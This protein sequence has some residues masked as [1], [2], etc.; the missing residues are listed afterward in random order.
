MG[1]S[2]RYELPFTLGYENTGW[3][4]ALGAGVD[5]LG[6]MAVHILRAVSA[7][8]IVAV[9]LDERKLGRAREPRPTF[10]LPE[11][12]LEVRPERLRERSGDRAERRDREHDER[13]GEDA[14][15]GASG[16]VE[17]RRLVRQAESHFPNGR[18]RPS[19]I[20]PEPSNHLV[21]SGV[22]G[23]RR[24][25]LRRWADG[26]EGSPVAELRAAGR[27]LSVL[28]EENERLANRLLA[29]ERQSGEPPPRVPARP[30]TRPR[31][32]R[33]RPPWQLAVAAIAIVALVAG[34]TA[35]A[36]RG[37]LDAGGAPSRGVVGA[38]GLGGLAFWA[39]VSDDGQA[40]WRL[41]GK[42]VSA[43]REGERLLL[44]PGKLPDGPHVVE[45]EVG[46]GLFD[47]AKKRFSFR[48]DTS[49]PVL[50]LDRPAAARR[51]Q[52]VQ[53]SGETEPGATIR[54]GGERVEVGED[55]RF[56]VRLAK[57]PTSGGV[58]L[59]V[60]DVA[61]NAS[62]WRVPVTVVPRRPAQP[63][64]AVHVTAYGWADDTLREGVLRL[65]RENRINAVE[66]DLKDE[67]GLVGWDAP[68]P[69]G[70]RIG[71]IEDVFDLAAAVR[72]LHEL[73]VRVIGRLVCFRD[74][75]HATAAWKA[76]RRDEVV[77]TPD[78]GPY[79][80]YG[81]FTNFANESVRRYNI[82]VA[83][84]A[85][86]LGVDEILYDYVRRPDGPLSSMRL[87]G[88]RGTAERSIA[89]FLE[90]SRAALTGTDALLGASVFGIAA[91]R[92][93][94]IAQDIPAIARVVD[95][96]SPMVYPS[97]WGPGEYGVSD[98]NGNPYAITRRSLTDFV[99][100]TRGTGARVVPWLQ[101]FSLGRTYGTAE[102]VA[103]I[104][105]ARD[106][107]ADEFLLWDASVTYT[108]A[109]LAPSAVRPALDVTAEPRGKLPGPKRLT[110]RTP[111]NP[112]AAPR[113]SL[114]PNELGVVPVVMHHEIRPDRVGAYDQTPAEFRAELEYLWEQGYIPVAAAEYARGDMD[115]PAGKSP[116]VLT[117]DDSTTYQLTLDGKGR[118]QP[119]TAVG[120][121][122]DFARTH[123][124]FRATGTF[125]VLREPFGGTAQSPAL[126]RWLVDRGFELGNHGHDHIALRTLGD[127]AVRQ[128]LVRGARVITDAVPGYEIRSMAL[129]LGSEPTRPMLA[130]RGRSDGTAY[131]PYAVFLVGAG[132]APSPFSTDFDPAAL[133]R[134][135]TSHQPW[136]NAEEYTF[137]DWF[138]R[139]SREPGLR[140]VSDGDPDRITVREADRS[141]LAPRFASRAVTSS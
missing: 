42:T 99:R 115:V 25:E 50:E 45:V 92:P 3:V 112:V 2:G 120:I 40:V 80:G 52:Q 24:D 114:P 141:N 138:P 108:A 83:V 130:V 96:I 129:P 86:K 95:Y 41:D 134:I 60:T 75:V 101:D 18:S 87:P 119:T 46:G 38:A 10:A 61:G 19:R 70:K 34:V 106:A 135:R 78:G 37:A 56:E 90:E 77:Q 27:A 117:F 5:G 68:V 133:P 33:R 118:P 35:T 94:E 51:D 73:G 59:T 105:A 26:L 57:P 100:L 124:G 58:V 140:Y 121:L 23:A 72:Q 31:R 49:A 6:Y 98:P 47:A 110:D 65:I 71:A 102:V 139:L 7:S 62:R 81:G 43:T 113:G 107:G 69:Y 109:A 14:E 93:H 79:A 128:Q 13:Q 16:S 21:C 132:P 39:H 63:V 48:V 82:D 22:D 91:T 88:L 29:L 125:F 55:G 32:A 11:A 126:L 122:L 30:A 116:V 54:R 4:E 67:G 85:T 1:S 104:R 89:A 136:S 9:D 74:P 8:R 137:A 36:T 66:L 111:R 12:A 20:E 97:H 131:G 127:E 84:A 28:C 15:H 53:M 44:R 64:R 76:G 123:P 17:R 103:Q